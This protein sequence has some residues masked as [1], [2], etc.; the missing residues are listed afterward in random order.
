MK[1]ILLFLTLCACRPA[2]GITIAAG[3]GPSLGITIATGTPEGTYYDIARDIQ[4]VAERDGIGVEII[5]T[6][7]SFDN[8]NLLGSGK[9]DLA[10]LQLDVL[11]FTFEVMRIE[12]GLNVLEELKVVLNL[13]FEEIHVIAK[14]VG[15]RSLEQLAGKRVAVGPEKSGSALTAE[16]LLAAHSLQVQKFFDSPSDALRKLESGELDALIFVGGA[17]LPAFEKLDKSFH[18]VE[19]PAS[20][21]LEQIYRKKKIDNTVYPW[22]GEIEVYSVPSVLMTR[23]RND[24]QYVA[25][26]QKLVLSILVNKEMLDATGH[27][28]WKSSFVRSVPHEGGYQPASDIIQMLNA[29]DSY[30]YRVIKK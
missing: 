6:N 7:G 23:A 12:A 5:Q 26:L 2:P 25:T 1:I 9:V 10:I 13:Y 3:T 4:R 29:L 18:F 14:N 21:V 15:I 8:I 16:V 24:L 30:G 20:A 17:P 19:L 22:T 11:K 28:K 27:A